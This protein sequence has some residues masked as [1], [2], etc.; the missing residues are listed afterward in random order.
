M[1]QTINTQQLKEK[2]DSKK[3]FFF[4]NVLPNEN[5]TAV[6]IPGSINVPVEYE[7]EF[8]KSIEKLIIDKNSEIVVYCSSSTCL[9]AER[10]AQ[11]LEEMGYTNVTHYPDGI[12]GWKEAGFAL[13]GEAVE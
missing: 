7:D 8:K 12:T 10:A 11:I 4:I 6:H 3:P 5:Y 9:A 13:A 2:L 1:I